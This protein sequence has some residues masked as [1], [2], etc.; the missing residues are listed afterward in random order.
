MSVINLHTVAA[1]TIRFDGAR[2]TTSHSGASYGSTQRDYV[3]AF[4][5]TLRRWQSETE[6]DSD[7]NIITS[8]PDFRSLVAL[9]QFT[10]RLILK[11][12]AQHP[13]PL[14][15]VLERAHSWA[16]YGQGEAGDFQVM[17]DAW[18]AWA[19]NERRRA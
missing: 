18:L 6:F 13:S 7:P 1:S 11:E 2:Q 10:E 12:L 19:N 16:P 15:W 3:S 17:T 5:E 14:V 8:H 4:Y 9:A